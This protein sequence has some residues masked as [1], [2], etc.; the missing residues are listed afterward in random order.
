[1]LKTNAKTINK[2]VNPKIVISVVE[3]PVVNVPFINVVLSETLNHS[4]L[5][6]TLDPAIKTAKTGIKATTKT[7][8]T[9]TPVISKD[10]LMLLNIRFMQIFKTLQHKY[11]MVFLLSEILS[12]PSDCQS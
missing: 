6:V 8:S 9:I 7:M 11:F 2:V 5:V 4:I 3:S 10:P 12:D 1:M